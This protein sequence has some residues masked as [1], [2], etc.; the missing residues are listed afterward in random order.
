[1][2]RPTVLITGCTKG[3]IGYSLA[4]EF[5]ARNYHVYA[6]TRRI[7]TMGDLV[8]VPNITALALDVT[9]RNSLLAAHAQIA[10][11]TDGRLDILYHN[12][13]YRSLA[14][15]VETSRDEVFK[16]FNANFFGIVEMN[17]I[18]A[19]LIISSK[20]KIVFTGSV[21]G[22]T[23]HP[24][25]SVYNSSKSAVA[26]YARTLRTEMKPF[27][28]RVV[29]VQTAAVSTGMSTN[30]VVLNPN[31]FYKYL[32]TKINS[33]WADLEADTLEPIAYAKAVVTKVAR[34]NPPN[35]IWCGSGALTVWAVEA[36][37]A[38][39]LYPLV[40]SRMFGL[41]DIAPQIKL[42]SRKERVA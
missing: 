19:D 29:F 24:S 36:L 3:S 21:S 6:S 15:A 31:S 32:E 34:A 42:E 37:G 7:A 23:P 27:G 11:E 39:W 9:D 38:H 14:M 22:Y 10:H 35:T 4:K 41:N 18:F 13:G 33:A 5:A 8:D 25:Q 20:G 1:M 2:V 28:V 12:A 40:F 17:A 26:M 30:R 16:M